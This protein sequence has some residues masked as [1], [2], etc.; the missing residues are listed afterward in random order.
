MNEKTVSKS[1]QGSN[2][3]QQIERY[4]VIVLVFLLVTIVAVSFWG[5]SKS[6]GFWSRLTGKTEP[7]KDTP[8]V[9]VAPSALVTDHVTDPLLPLSIQPGTATPTPETGAPI[10]N[11]NMTSATDV[12]L[13]G[14]GTLGGAQPNPFVPPA[15]N[16]NL[17]PATGASVT[18]APSAPAGTVSYTI[19]RGDSLALIAKRRLGA[20]SRWTDIQAANPGLDPKR[21]APGTTIQLPA[22][23]K[24]GAPSTIVASAATKAAPKPKRGGGEG[25]RAGTKSYTIRKGDVLRAIARRELGDEGRWKEI[26]ALNPGLDPARLAVGATIKLPSGGERSSAPSPKSPSGTVLASADK[27]RVK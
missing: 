5:D 23:A 3:M 1:P 11:G 25:T 12:P 19:Q 18:P 22:D 20:E 15:P 9:V 24:A 7:K 14:N 4:G 13:A 27:P 17:P 2:K 6:P 10:V 26:V 16:V 21:L 8:E